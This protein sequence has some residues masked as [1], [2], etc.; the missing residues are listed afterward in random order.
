M[1]NACTQSDQHLC[2]PLLRQYDTYT[3]Y[4]QSFMF[5]AFFFCW[6]VWFESFLVEN[7]RRHVRVMWLNFLQFAKKYD[8]GDYKL[9]FEI[10][11]IHW[12]EVNKKS[13][14]APETLLFLGTVY[15]L[16]TL[17]HSSSFSSVDEGY[18]KIA[19]SSVWEFENFC[20]Q[21][22]RVSTNRQI[23]QDSATVSGVL[24]KN[25]K[26]TD[27]TVWTCRLSDQCLYSSHIT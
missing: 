15:F 14:S 27:Q 8:V 16:N 19:S 13:I 5:L 25:N 6:A 1:P 2:W 20:L 17:W 22:L 26:G 4:V 24:N 7:P 10:S 18:L 21:P 12:G 3:F 11:Q 23:R 9:W